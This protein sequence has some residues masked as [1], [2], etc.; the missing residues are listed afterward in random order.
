[1][2]D[3]N[4]ILTMTEQGW[5]KNPLFCQTLS[6]WLESAPSRNP[7]L[8]LDLFYLEQCLGGWGGVFPYAYGQDGRFMVFPFCH[9]DIIS[10][11]LSLPLAV[12]REGSLARLVAEREWPALLRYPFNQAHGLQ[13]IGLAWYR[14]RQWARAV[15][16]RRVAWRSV[17]AINRLR[18]RVSLFLGASVLM[19][20]ILGTIYRCFVMGEPIIW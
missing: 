15:R 7:F 4:R 5:E 3:L 12:R 19:E 17:Q 2:I 8:V 10:A 18:K 13:Q 11:I 6:R 16:L 14:V 20:L 9:R 1:V